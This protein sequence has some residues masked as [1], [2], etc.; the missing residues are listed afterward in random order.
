[1]RTPALL[2][3]RGPSSL[4][5]ALA[6][7]ISR[8]R[9]AWTSKLASQQEFLS[10]LQAS[11]LYFCFEETFESTKNNSVMGTDSSTNREADPFLD[12][13]KEEFIHRGLGS[14][15]MSAPS[16]SATFGTGRAKRQAMDFLLR[17]NPTQETAKSLDVSRA[18]A[19]PSA[20]SA[21]ASIAAGFSKPKTRVEETLFFIP[22]PPRKGDA[23]N[24][25]AVPEGQF[26]SSATLKGWNFANAFANYNFRKNPAQTEAQVP[27]LEQGPIV[28]DMLTQ[29]ESAEAAFGLL[30]KSQTDGRREPSE[31]ATAIST[32][33]GAAARPQARKLG[34]V[35]FEID[36]QHAAQMKALHDRFEKYSNATWSGALLT[37]PSA[38]LPIP[39]DDAQ[40]FETREASGG[41]E[42][43][44]ETQS[45]SD[46]LPEEAEGASV[47]HGAGGAHFSRGDRS[48]EKRLQHKTQA[49]PDTA[50]NVGAAY[51]SLATRR[52]NLRGAKDA[53]GDRPSTQQSVAFEAN[54]SQASAEGADHI[55]GRQA[56]T[57]TSDLEQPH[58]SRPRF[59][60][61]S[62]LTS[63]TPSRPA[64]TS[65]TDLPKLP[66]F[67]VSASIGTGTHADAE[68]SASHHAGTS[69]PSATSADVN[70]PSP[71]PRKHT[72]SDSES[73]NNEDIDQLHLLQQ[74]MSAYM[75]SRTPQAPSNDTEVEWLLPTPP[76]VTPAVD[77]GSLAT[78]G[79]STTLPGQLPAA[80][81]LASKAMP[82]SK[83]RQV[84]MSPG[85]ALQ[86]RALHAWALY[87]AQQ[88][89]EPYSMQKAPGARGSPI[90]RPPT[91]ETGADEGA[92][93][94]TEDYVW[95]LARA[96]AQRAWDSAVSEEASPASA[97]GC[98]AARAPPTA[99]RER[100]PDRQ[101]LMR[102]LKMWRSFP[103]ILKA[104]RRSLEQEASAREQ[105]GLQ[106]QMQASLEAQRQHLAQEA[107]AKLEVERLA[108]QNERQQLEREAEAQLQTGI[109]SLHQYAAAALEAER[110]A[111]QAESKK[112]VEEAAEHRLMASTEAGAQQSAGK[113]RL[114]Q[115]Q[116][117][118]AALEVERM[119]LERAG[120]AAL[121][122][123]RAVLRVERQRLQQEAQGRLQAEQQR[124]Q[125]QAEAELQA[126]RERLQA[127]MQNLESAAEQEAQAAAEQQRLKQEAQV[128]A[129]QQRLQ[130]EAQ[131]AAEAQMAA[132]QQRMKQEGQMAAEQEHL[133]QKV[134]AAAEAQ[135]AEEQQRLQQ[136]AQAAAEHRMAAEQQRLQQEAQAAAEAQ[137]AAEQ[138]RMKQEG[139]MAAEQE[140]LQQKVQAAAE[141]QMAEE[142]Q[143]LQQEAQAAASTD[144]Q[145]STTTVPAG[146][147]GWLAA[148]H[149][150]AAEQQRLQGRH[151]DGDEDKQRPWA[152]GNRRRRV[153]RMAADEAAAPLQQEASGGGE[154][155]W[156]RCSK[157]LWQQEALMRRS[158]HWMARASR[159]QLQEAQ[160]AEA[161]AIQTGAE[162]AASF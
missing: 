34:E 51:S 119:R 63:L 102:T 94:P 21:A 124:L 37:P 38:P 161:E 97:L 137:M 125:Q 144:L 28:D 40:G 157:C 100:D 80:S 39:H 67:H 86:W 36:A 23:S 109:R 79:L 70:E 151:T 18:A 60:S 46:S 115:E 93:G 104:E 52:S 158:R 81:R 50:F 122:E 99:V 7:Y 139:Q 105:Q 89:H 29:R 98:N 2:G 58:H 9:S 87:A 24:A 73:G 77:S 65:T 133:Q 153:P 141:A 32:I 146:G 1:M 14:S 62:D 131:A 128:A 82:F 11:E 15:P 61:T 162:R 43:D 145:K 160:Q 57:S 42:E 116:D 88:M 41:V 127:E 19:S 8:E 135:M 136:E 4:G 112:L 44:A 54:T 22:I 159:F 113:Q 152:G 134:Q 114:E 26:A 47:E 13:M 83:A 56:S 59:T 143:R 96:A 64:A 118:K 6:L 68:E 142:Q 48:H 71:P 138:Q 148:E 150:M 33:Q 72:V 156:H 92:Q 3:C 110:T 75:V 140:H 117:A 101:L 27:R 20:T 106:W 49:A 107:Q 55:P 16:T 45:D 31:S 132:E 147:T 76:R 84:E 25:A 35:D 123:E 10:A 91:S 95:Q 69:Q 111:L 155:R 103:E 120:Q 74:R 78:P 154:H 129:E 85:A 12:R 126:E 53:Q 130:Q 108:L 90:D 5:C 121:E 17:S 66:N 30:R 149:Q